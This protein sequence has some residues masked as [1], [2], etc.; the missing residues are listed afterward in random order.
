MKS[1]AP[2]R[3]IVFADAGNRT[4]NQPSSEPVDQKRQQ[5]DRRRREPERDLPCPWCAAAASEASETVATAAAWMPSGRRSTA[6][7]PR[8]CPEP[9]RPTSSSIHEP[10]GRA[11]ARASGRSPVDV[12]ATTAGVSSL[13]STIVSVRSVGGGQDEL[14]EIG[15]QGGR[16]HRLDCA[17]RNRRPRQPRSAVPCRGDR[18][19]RFARRRGSRDTPRCR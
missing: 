16:V 19:R 11:S 1:P 9:R 14:V 3:V 4:M 5:H 6:R 2:A 13:I 17:A 10:L 18:A 15:S 7:R 12:L 8:R